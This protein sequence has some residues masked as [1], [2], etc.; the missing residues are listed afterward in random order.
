MLHQATLAFGQREA[1]DD[2]LTVASPTAGFELAQVG[3]FFEW[4]DESADREFRRDRRCHGEPH[5]TVWASN[6]SSETYLLID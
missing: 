4:F 6:R 2:R 1:G 5:G 3:R